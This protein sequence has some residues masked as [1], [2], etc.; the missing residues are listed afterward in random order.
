V[1]ANPEPGY[2]PIVENAERSIPT[3]YPDGPYVFCC[4]DAFEMER[5]MK[6]ILLPEPIGFASAFFD[7]FRERFVCSPE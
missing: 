1:P 5:R 7:A 6:G 3:G 2:Y 4:I